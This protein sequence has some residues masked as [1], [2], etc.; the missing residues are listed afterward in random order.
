MTKRVEKHRLNI[1]GRYYVDQDRCLDHGMCEYRAPDNFRLDVEA[2]GA[3]VFKQPETREEETNVKRA[4]RN[5]PVQAIL[6]D[7]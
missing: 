2:Y 3:Y 6:N 5:C 7:G 1:S 4:M